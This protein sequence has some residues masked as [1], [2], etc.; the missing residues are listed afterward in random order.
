MISSLWLTRN[1]CARFGRFARSSRA[2]RRVGV[3]IWPELSWVS[4][5]GQ[6]LSQPCAF[7]RHLGANHHKKHHDQNEQQSVD[8]GDGCYAAAQQVFEPIHQRA[9]QVSE[10]DGEQKCN[11]SGAG[12]IEK[13]RPSAN[14]STVTRT[15]AV[16][17][18]ASSNKFSR[19]F[20]IPPPGRHSFNPGPLPCYRQKSL[21]V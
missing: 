3:A 16:R 11:Q 19:A 4:N 6:G 9:H 2:L 17:E 1:D 7:P 8:H 21:L 5:S 10:E 18:S 13:P 20:S 12:D 15:R 14:S